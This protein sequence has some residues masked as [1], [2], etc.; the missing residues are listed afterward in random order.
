[1]EVESV[2]RQPNELLAKIEMDRSYRKSENESGVFS[3]NSSAN[4]HD[5][6][7]EFL[8][9]EI[10]DPD[11][12]DPPILQSSNLNGIRLSYNISS[13]EGDLASSRVGEHLDFCVGESC[14]LITLYRKKLQFNG[15]WKRKEWQLG[16]WFSL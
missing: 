11:V 1:M 12:F 9:D 13:I 2:A 10:A 14:T 6:S 15:N 5:S 4:S 7:W 3:N 8:E 16:L